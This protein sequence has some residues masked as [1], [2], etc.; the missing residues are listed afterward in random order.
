LLNARA[1]MKTSLGVGVLVVGLVLATGCSGGNDGGGNN[2][3]STSMGASGSGGSS[4]PQAGVG[5]SS[6]GAGGTASTGGAAGS[7]GDAGA[8]GAAG[9]DGG[10]T[11][12]GPGSVTPEDACHR[13]ATALCAKLSQCASLVA[14]QYG[15]AP[16]CVT[17]MQSDCLRGFAASQG[18]TAAKQAACTDAVSSGTCDVIYHSPTACQHTGSGAAGS[19]CLSD[20]D[21]TE[22][23]SCYAQTGAK[24]ACG[25]C[26]K[27]AK[28]GESCAA[29]PCAEGLRCNT[30]GTCYV[31]AKA[32]E[33]CFAGKL[34]GFPLVCGQ[35]GDPCH[36]PK[37]LGATCGPT[38]DDCDQL[39]GVH[40]NPASHTCTATLIATTLGDHCGYDS[41][42][43]NNTFCGAGLRC[44]SNDF[45]LGLCNR[46][47]TI[48]QTCQL[49]ANG[50]DPCAAGLYCVGTCQLPD[51]ATCTP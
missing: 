26:T 50:N 12:G 44:S 1:D 42:N 24:T 17:A 5:G 18:W 35:T 25:V 27:V 7:G 28:E 31:P 9:G 21:C 51:K 11:E 29:A 3:A 39:N 36:A 23:S 2:A 16:D 47:G 48:G 6:G 45:K 40:C 46:T 38:V 19:A 49:D 32:G 15:T 13:H 10:P 41:T 20:V 37:P 14:V 34:C 43:G 8:A 22:G 4:G 33:G 30:T